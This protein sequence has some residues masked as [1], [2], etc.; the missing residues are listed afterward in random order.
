[1]VNIFFTQT[2]YPPAVG[3]AQEYLHQLARLLAERH[4]VQVASFWAVNR[5][6][7]LLGTTWLAPGGRPYVLDNVPV[8]LINLSRLERLRLS[9]WV[10]SY[11]LWQSQ[12]IRRIA[13]VILPHLRQIA[14]RVDLIHHGRVG[15]EPLAFASLALARELDIPFVLTPLHHP[16]WGGWLYRHYHHLYRQADAV[17][18]L[19][20]AERDTLI[21]LGVRPERIFVTG[22]GAVLSS[23][24]TISSPEFPQFLGNLRNSKELKGQVMEEQFQYDAADFRRRY[25]L[26][27]PIVLFLG[28]KYPYKGFRPLLTAAPLVW[29]QCPE[30]CFVFIG[31]R[32]RASQRVFRRVGDSRIVE[33]GAVSLA[34]KT[35]A[36][37]ACDVL[38]VPSTQESFGGVY[39]EAWQMGKP[40]IG[41]NIATVSQVISD[42]VDGFV[43]PAEP[44]FLA[45]R[46]RQLL[47]D[48][49][50][51]ARMG[52]AGRRKAEQ[53]YDWRALAGRTVE[54]YESL[55][56]LG[57]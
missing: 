16:R 18:A 14:G 25:R 45:G 43:G 29:E 21:A 56:G 20:P 8:T 35:A 2:A 33:L 41:A 40:V 28:Q 53:L 32:T 9:P 3:G 57:D 15:R 13:G 24:P 22:T 51:R 44:T 10:L 7:W 42:G 38:C 47:R 36:L 11:Y 46:L 4:Q 27:G 26:S 54:I 34:E 17:M 5:T 50:L 37:A 49:T 19:T 31:P 1:M 55:R 23:A 52:E 30:T 48:P 12:A 39:V 6:D